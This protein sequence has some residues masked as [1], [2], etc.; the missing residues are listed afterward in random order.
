LDYS[1]VSGEF[2]T[3]DDNPRLLVHLDDE[4]GQGLVALVLAP[5]Q[6]DPPELFSVN[7]VISLLEVNEGRVVAPL[8]ALP[9]VDLG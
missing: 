4:E 3:T 7:G 6:K 5:T 2:V 8:L 9:G 1:Q